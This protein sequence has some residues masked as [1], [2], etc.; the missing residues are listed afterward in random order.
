MAQ[1]STDEGYVGAWVEAVPGSPEPITAMGGRPSKGHVS[2]T[3]YNPLMTNRQ[4]DIIVL[5]M[6]WLLS[7]LAG[8]TL[9]LTWL[10]L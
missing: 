1:S 10:M 6:I 9:G 3:V 5:L 8:L 7:I 4:H 2:M